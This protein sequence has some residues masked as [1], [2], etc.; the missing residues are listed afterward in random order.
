MIWDF[1]T[2]LTL[3]VFVS[4]IIWACDSLLFAPARAR[5]RRSAARL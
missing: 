5:T 1:A 3:L 4:G 2:I